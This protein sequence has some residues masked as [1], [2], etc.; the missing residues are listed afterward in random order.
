[1]KKM[2][3]EIS[4]GLSPSIVNDMIY[5]V[6]EKNRLFFFAFL[7]HIETDVVCRNFDSLDHLEI[8]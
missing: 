6:L 4:L 7:L 1:M 3:K 8:A 2:M 5:S